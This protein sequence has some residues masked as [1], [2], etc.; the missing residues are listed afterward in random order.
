MHT[1][2][3]LLLAL[4]GSSF[5]AANAQSTDPSLVCQA[6]LVHMSSQLTTTCCVPATNC[7]GGFPTECNAACAVLWN[8]FAATCASY[9]EANLPQLADLDSKCTATGGGSGSLDLGTVSTT[10]YLSVTVGFTA[11]ASVLAP[12]KKQNR[13][14]GEFA[15]DV[16]EALSV[17]SNAVYLTSVTANSISFDIFATSQADANT[18]QTNLQGQFADPNSSLMTGFVSDNIQNP[19]QATISIQTTGGSGGGGAPPPPGTPVPGTLKIRVD[20]QSDVYFNGE[21]LGSTTP[22]QWTRTESFDFVGTCPAAA[23]D[24]YHTGNGNVLAFH[25]IDNAGV[26]AVIASWDHCGSTATTNLGCRC[27]SDDVSADDWTAVSY[28]D[29]AWPYAADGGGN[30]VDPWGVNPEIDRDARW[31]WAADLFGTDEAFC[32]CKEHQLATMTGTDLSGHG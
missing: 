15:S 5:L 12:G 24:Q 13:F 19:G 14:K 26:S 31:I 29:S 1:R 23:M 10:Y 28:D 4:A 32:R 17:S 22:S 8:P 25:G 11:R 30:G 16:A 3:S 27:T 7:D 18:M 20:D 21:L 2:S 9:I 6:Q